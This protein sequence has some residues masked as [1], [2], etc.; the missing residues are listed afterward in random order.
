MRR[1]SL[2]LL[3]L[4]LIGAA[5]GRAEILERVVVKVNDQIVTLSEFQARQLAAVQEAKVGPSEVERYLRANNARILQEAI[6]EILLM[7]RA[8][9][10]GWRLPPEAIEEVV[11]SIKRENNITSEAQMKEALAREG[12]TIEDL[13][14][15]I[16]RSMTKR[17]V[18]DRDVRPKVTATD[19]ECLAEYQK[20]EAT[21][22][23]KAPTVTLKE[24]VVS[25]A[26]G[27]LDVARQ[28]VE[29]ARA[30]EDFSTLARNYSSA[31]SRATGG[32][33]GPIARGGLDPEVEKV[34][35]ALAVGSVSDPIRVSGGY[36][37]VKVIAQTPGGVV[38]FETAK[39]QVRERILAP[40][41]EQ[42]YEAY[43]KELRTDATVEMRA[44]DVPVQ[45]PE[46]PAAGPTQPR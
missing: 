1:W 19:A 20:L 23:T 41:L 37:I 39:A 30:G 40:R 6:D 38:P 33:I 31:P 36:R 28:I 2:F 17:L 16:E 18:V 44:R 42:A 14:R 13:R 5:P 9:E 3:V 35:F 11:A 10:A 22:F 24:I 27:G 34:A 7:K 45:L 32:D 26:A 15:K 43:M 21:E 29:K 12:T 25:D 46:M 8:E 4:D